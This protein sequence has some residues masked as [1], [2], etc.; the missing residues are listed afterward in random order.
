MRVFLGLCYPTVIIL[1]HTNRLDGQNLRRHLGL[2]IHD[3]RPVFRGT[4]VHQLSPRKLASAHD[5]GTRLVARVSEGTTIYV[6]SLS[7]KVPV[8]DPSIEALQR[9]P[10]PKAFNH[11]PVRFFRP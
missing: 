2:T 11:N 8:T 7:D 1:S 3:G 4:I 9:T 5:L 6:V 10:L